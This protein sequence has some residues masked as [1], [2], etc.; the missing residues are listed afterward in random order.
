MKTI[1]VQVPEAEGTG[2]PPI[3]TADPDFPVQNPSWVLVFSEDGVVSAMLEPGW[4]YDKA[5]AAL[6]SV[7]EILMRSAGYFDRDSDPLDW[8]KDGSEQ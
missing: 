3:I 4:K 1:T 7:Q 2:E 5:L 8:F 6:T